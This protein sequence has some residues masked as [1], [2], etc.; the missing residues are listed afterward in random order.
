[1]S[2]RKSII[3]SRRSGSHLDL[4][5]SHLIPTNLIKAIEECI[6]LGRVDKEAST[7][8]R[9]LAKFIVDVSSDPT[10]GL[11]AGLYEHE[12]RKIKELWE[13]LTCHGSTRMPAVLLERRRTTQSRKP[14]SQQ[15][16][17]VSE[18][19]RRIAL[20]AA[21]KLRLENLHKLKT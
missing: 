19:A 3:Q 10:V 4:S 8:D 6:A 16:R 11:A 20:E 17:I 1:M 2:T 5:E 18:M 9:I 14:A 7:Q 15:D 13:G 21:V 12:I